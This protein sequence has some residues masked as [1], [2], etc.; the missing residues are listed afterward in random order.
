M[1]NSVDKRGGSKR[2]KVILLNGRE[3]FFPYYVLDH[4]IRKKAII[5][6]ERSDGWVRIDRDPI[7]KT[8]SSERF[9]GPKKRFTDFLVKKRSTDWVF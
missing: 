9:S 3:E 5:A 1:S 4:F 6:F 8:R 2:I 7:R